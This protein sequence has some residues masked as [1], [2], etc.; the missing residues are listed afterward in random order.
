MYQYSLAWFLALFDASIKAA[1]K[2]SVL[3]KRTEALVTHFQYSLY[4]QV[5]R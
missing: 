4:V 2:S 3:A 5:C 1:E